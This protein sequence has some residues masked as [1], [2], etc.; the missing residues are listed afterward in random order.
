MAEPIA[1]LQNFAPEPRAAYL[2]ALRAAMP[3]EIVLPY[4]EI[5]RDQRAAV[6]IGIAATTSRAELAELPNL[7]LVHSLWAGIDRLVAELGDKAPAVVRLVN[8]EQARRMGEAALAWC[9]YLQRDMPAYAAQQAGKVWRQLRY[10]PPSSIAVGVLGLGVMGAAAITRLREASF[11]VTGWSRTRQSLS[12]VETMAG[13]DGL[14][15]LLGASDIVVCLLPLTPETSRLLNAERLASMKPGAALI[16]FSRGE[17]VAEDALL[18]ALDSGQ[19]GHAVLDVFEREPLPVA[20]RLWMHPSV[21][22]LPH[23]SA[24]TDAASTAAIIAGNIAQ[25]RRDG[26]LPRTVDVS[27][28]Y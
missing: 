25:F 23:I 5:D 7:L 15:H 16:N 8:P 1:F 11:Q 12:G 27:R 14:A 13:P 2:G 18:A 17:I 3:A 4:D 26:T 28:G 24:P 9:L 10:R 6:R 21:T 22:V 20:S 19:I